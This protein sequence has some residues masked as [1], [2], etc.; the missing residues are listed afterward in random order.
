MTQVQ[1][2]QLIIDAL[3]SALQVKG[4]TDKA[5]K[6]VAGQNVIMV[7]HGTDQGASQSKLPT[8]PWSSTILVGPGN[9]RYKGGLFRH[10]IMG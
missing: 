4:W 10:D 6:C 3:P 8:L 7:D 5:R 1:G 2:S 9:P